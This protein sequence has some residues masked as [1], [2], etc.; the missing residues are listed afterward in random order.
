MNTFLM[1]NPQQLAQGDHTVF[2][3]GNDAEAKAQVTD[4][5]HA[6]GWTDVIELGD[7]TTARGTEMLLPIWLRLWGT[8]RTGLFNVK[9]VR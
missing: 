7:I 1:A 2:V 3:S 6:F 5:L 9:V 8:L 4:I